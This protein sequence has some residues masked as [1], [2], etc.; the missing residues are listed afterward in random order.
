MSSAA[1]PDV[2][3]VPPSMAVTLPSAA[4]PDINNFSF[5][6]D[7]RSAVLHRLLL[8]VLFF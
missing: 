5:I 8:F 4:Q 2:N 3:V 6:V 7:L 1:Q